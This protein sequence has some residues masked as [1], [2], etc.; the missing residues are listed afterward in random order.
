M[1]FGK[2]DIAKNISSKAQISLEASKQI[3]NEFIDII[4]TKSVIKEV[5]ISN[6]GTFHIHKSPKRV[7]RNP[8]TKQEYIIPKRS[9]LSLKVSPKIKDFLN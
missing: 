2:K 7:G 4:R 3:L 6:F 1:G 5:K 9:K 8:K